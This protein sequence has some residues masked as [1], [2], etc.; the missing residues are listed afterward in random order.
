MHN[1]RLAERLNH[2]VEPIAVSKTPKKRSA[3]ALP[4][5]T[6]A[7]SY[8]QT[9]PARRRRLLVHWGAWRLWWPDIAS[10]YRAVLTPSRGEESRLR[11]DGESRGEE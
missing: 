4:I 8:S 1:R 3:D 7:T 9:D 5:V 2:S 11:R 6:L 10:R